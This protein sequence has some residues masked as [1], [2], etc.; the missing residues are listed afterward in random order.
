MSY[1]TLASRWMK[2]SELMVLGVGVALIIHFSG[3]P[4]VLVTQLGS[5][6]FGILM[7]VSGLSALVI[8]LVS[9]KTHK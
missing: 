2:S 5:L 9:K 7:S 1:K 8:Q 6:P 3:L 4:S